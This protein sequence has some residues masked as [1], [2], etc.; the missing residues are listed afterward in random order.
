MKTVSTARRTYMGGQ[1]Q[2]EATCWLCVRKDGTILGFTDHDADIT[3]NLASAMAALSLAV[4]PGISGTG[5]V[6]YRAASGFTSSNIQKTL[7]LNVDTGEAQGV[8]VS[9]SI[10]ETDLRAGLWDA[11]KIAIFQVNWSDLT[12]GGIILSAGKTGQIVV[13]RGFFRAEWRGKLASYGATIGQLTSAF[14]PYVLGHVGGVGDCNKDL[15]AFT[16]T[17]TIDSVNPDNRT[18][19]DSARAEAGP[20]G[21]IAITGVSNANPGIVTLASPWTGHAGDAVIIYGVG[22]MTAINTTTVIRKPSG[23]TFQL[24][25]DTTDT[26]DYPAYTSGGH[27]IG[28]G[29]DAGY[30]DGGVITFTS[31]AN[32]GLSME[33]RDYKAGQWTLQ[34]PMPYVIL[35]GDTYTMKA[36][37]DHSF[38]TCRDKFDNTINFGGFPD[39]PGVDKLIQVER[40]Q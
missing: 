33:V 26:A 22:G 38:G 20:T 28:L 2:T 16:V 17:G 23:S 3:F 21:G 27:V 12:M 29:G 9:P 14:C 35:A 30:F 7:G 37:C 11:C 8:L 4:P 24:G 40:R 31:G 25:I 6:T 18:L 1:E 34:L 32:V 39:F 36:G 5:L 19:Y 15:T 10:T 13:D